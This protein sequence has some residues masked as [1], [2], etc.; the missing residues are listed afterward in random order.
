MLAVAKVF[1]LASEA[2]HHKWVASILGNVPP[3]AWEVGLHGEDQV[4]PTKDSSL[5]LWSNGVLE[6][7][8]ENLRIGQIRQQIFS[9]LLKAMPPLRRKQYEPMMHWIVD[10]TNAPVC[11][12]KDALGSDTFFGH[13]IALLE[14]WQDMQ[15]QENE[16]AWLQHHQWPRDRAIPPAQIQAMSRQAFDYL[17]EVLANWLEEEPTNKQPVPDSLLALISANLSANRVLIEFAAKEARGREAAELAV[18]IVEKLN[19][20]D[21]TEIPESMHLGPAG[22]LLRLKTLL[23]NW[24][25]PRGRLIGSSFGFQR[26][27]NHSDIDLTVKWSMQLQGDYICSRG[28]RGGQEEAMENHGKPMHLFIFALTLVGAFYSN[29][30]TDNEFKGK[31]NSSY[32]VFPGRKLIAKG[33]SEIPP[34][35]AA[36]LLKQAYG[37]IYFGNVGWNILADGVRDYAT[38]CSV[39]RSHIQQLVR[40]AIKNRTSSTLLELNKRLSE[41][42]DIP[43][44]HFANEMTRIG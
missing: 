29:A 8:E 7:S 13:T 39:K 5:R 19:N 24:F 31:S 10:P 21:I 14:Q 2:L 22:A 32:A 28:H 6:P 30:K 40:F 9:E 11:L 4:M 37:L 34:P 20:L 23:T 44:L 16:R 42:K 3:E 15:L 33:A 12:A 43:P 41:A 26:P 27:M 17:K 1:N 38:T 25:G 18:G 36:E 35:H